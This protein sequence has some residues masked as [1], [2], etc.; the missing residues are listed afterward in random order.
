MSHTKSGP[1]DAGMPGPASEGHT[2]CPWF[3]HGG[4]AIFSYSHGEHSGGWVASTKQSMGAFTAEE[5]K[6]NAAFIVEAV[7]AYGGMM[8][9]LR[10]F[11]DE[12]LTLMPEFERFLEESEEGEQA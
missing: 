10:K 7:N 1:R 12:G 9:L 6:A 11:R 8:I 3:H 4:Q 2:P 5:A